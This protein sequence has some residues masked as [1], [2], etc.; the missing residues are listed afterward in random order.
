MELPGYIRRPLEDAS[1]RGL[2]HDHIVVGFVGP[3]CLA[4]F[5]VLDGDGRI[6]DGVARMTTRADYREWMGRLMDEATRRGARLAVCELS[7]ETMSA[8]IAA[9]G[10]LN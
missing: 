2:Y 6:I 8:A 1:A 9:R 10:R 3:T 4:W 7:D 5:A